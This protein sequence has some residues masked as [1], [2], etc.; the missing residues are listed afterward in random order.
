M[1]VTN[2]TGADA[3]V[4]AKYIK[5]VM[6]RLRARGKASQR[7]SLFYLVCT[8]AT[9]VF[10]VVGIIYSPILLEIDQ[11]TLQPNYVNEII[12]NNA[13]EIAEIDLR[14]RNLEEVVDAF[15]LQSITL[16]RT[17]QTGIAVGYSGTMLL[18]LDGG[19]NWRQHELPETFDLT[20][21]A[22]SDDGRNA[23]AVGNSG[24]VL[25]TSD[26]GEN[27]ERISDELVTSE[28]F[29]T[30]E[31]SGDGL[32]AIAIADS[33]AIISTEDGGTNWADV[34]PDIG[35]YWN[36]VALNSDGSVGIVVGDGGH[37]L[38]TRDVGETWVSPDWIPENDN[39]QLQTIGWFYDVKITPDGEWIIA[40]GDYGWIITVQG[41]DA[42]LTMTQLPLDADLEYLAIGTD[43]RTAIA[44]PFQGGPMLITE[45]RGNDWMESSSPVFLDQSLWD[46]ALSPD[47]RTAFAIG[48]SA[49]FLSLDGG[50]TWLDYNVNLAERRDGLV[51]QRDSLVQENRNLELMLIGSQSAQQSDSGNSD[52][53]SSWTYFTITTS[54]RIVIVVLTVVLI[55]VFVGL[56]RYNRRLAAFYL[57]RYDALSL[58]DTDAESVSVETVERVTWILSPDLVDFEKTPKALTG[59]AVNL[60]HTLSTSVGRRGISP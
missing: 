31:I 6:E 59:K 58:L 54:W 57:S 20:S 3:Q 24:T 36:A 15:L 10:A 35:S 56:N 38:M 8:V 29:R 49:L 14:I 43:G 60:A 7:G 30:I 37:P 28:D 51:Q 13:E 39:S 21:V 45:N 18:S 44:A 50:H 26:R 48:D 32:K 40:V 55:Q 17:S 12:Q 16:S 23:I 25:V 11:R 34:T 27:W 9:L 19:I 1:A 4:S 52:A 47:G 33:G 5:T 2:G 46:I 41:P 53:E 42:S 22:I